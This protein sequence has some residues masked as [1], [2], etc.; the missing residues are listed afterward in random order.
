[1]INYE[2]AITIDDLPAHKSSSAIYINEQILKALDEFKAPAI[3]FVNEGSLKD[4]TI[5]RDVLKLWIDYGQTL[6]N[7]TYSHPAL[8]KTKLKDFEEE[9]IKGALISKELKYPYRYFRH[10]YLDTGR[11]PEIRSSFEAFLKKE[12]YIIAPITIDTD[13]WKF[14]KQL[15]EDPKNS[16]EIIQKYLDHTRNKF[17]FYE[18]VSKK[19]FGH[20]IKHT[21]LLHVNLLN[22]YAMKD[23]LK[24]VQGLG[25]K[26]IT[27]DKALED[28]A[29]NELY[30][31]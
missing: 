11:T 20:N 19:I 10:P 1:M 30:R 2:I 17:V 7:H 6:G 27:L 9:V 22:A 29:Y 26:F 28:K 31:H 18:M 23:L 25:Y 16:Q 5:T 24:M 14:N 3:G 15:L 8:S 12:G 13:D 4:S 21:W